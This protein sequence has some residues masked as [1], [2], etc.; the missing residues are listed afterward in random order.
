MT[1][2]AS[3]LGSLGEALNVVADVAN[4]A[5]RRTIN[6]AI[7][8]NNP[9][10]TAAQMVNAINILSGQT[11][12]QTVVTASAAALLALIPN[13]G[14]GQTFDFTIQNGHTSTGTVTLSPGAGVTV[15]N[16]YATA[17]Q[18]ITT[19]RTYRGIVTNVGTPAITIYPI[20]QVS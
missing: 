9:T 4:G 7:T 11:G 12:A 18:P 15:T 14:V 16:T 20:A 13:A 2:F 1:R 6:A 3:T 17:A 8:G 19:T 5:S 10:L